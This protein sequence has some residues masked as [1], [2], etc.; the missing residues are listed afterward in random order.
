MGSEEENEDDR[1]QSPIS[2]DP[3]ATYTTYDSKAKTLARSDSEILR[4]AGITVNVLIEFQ[5][6]GNPSFIKKN[7]IIC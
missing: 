7:Y 1:N 5:D 3:L 4:T 6:T 2:E